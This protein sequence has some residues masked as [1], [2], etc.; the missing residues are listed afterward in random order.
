MKINPNLSYILHS[1]Q[2]NIIQIHFAVENFEHSS[3][4]MKFQQRSF[5][6][7]ADENVVFPNQRT[8]RYR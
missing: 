4:A 8:M 2:I 3:S 7:F 6:G 1:I 5:H